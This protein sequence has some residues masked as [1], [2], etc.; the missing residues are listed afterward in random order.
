MWSDSTCLLLTLILE[1]LVLMVGKIPLPDSSPGLSES[2]T[3]DS[4]TIQILPLTTILPV[5]LVLHPAPCQPAGCH[6]T[7]TLTRPT[8]TPSAGTGC[9]CPLGFCRPR[10]VGREDSSHAEV[11]LSRSSFMQEKNIV[12]L[13]LVLPENF[14]FSSMVSW[15]PS[16]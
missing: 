2:N 4:K 3:K 12:L 6:P 11:P 16:V 8:G 7:V 15:K 14:L 10:E 9:R 13:C 5:V 1:T